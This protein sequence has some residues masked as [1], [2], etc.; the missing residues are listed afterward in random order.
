MR[1]GYECAE[2]GTVYT[3]SRARISRGADKYMLIELPDC[4]QGSAWGGRNESLAGTR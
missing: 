1:A 4:E 3:D 2:D